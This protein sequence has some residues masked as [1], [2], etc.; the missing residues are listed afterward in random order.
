MKT[1]YE[2]TKLKA[3]LK[4]KGI[5]A[6]KLSV[7]CSIATTNIYNSLNGKQYIYPKWRKAISEYLN[8]PEEDIFI[9]SYDELKEKNEM[10]M[11]LMKKR[12]KKIINE[13]TELLEEM[14]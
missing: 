6:Y 3:I 5:S 14:E 10:D 9:D 13:L 11:A 7:D 4:E 1:L 12:L 8:M 2:Q